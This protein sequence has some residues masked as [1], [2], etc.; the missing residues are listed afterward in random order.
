MARS[1][2]SLG[3][4]S[5]RAARIA[6]RRRAFMAGSGSPSLA[7]TVISRAS[8]ENNCE[9][10]L[11][12]RPLRCMMF[13]NCECPAMASPIDVWARSAP[14]GQR[15]R[16]DRRLPEWRRVI[17]WRLGKIQNAPAMADASIRHRTSDLTHA[18]GVLDRPDQGL[19]P[20]AQV[21]HQSRIGDEAAVVVDHGIGE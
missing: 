19:E 18:A 11:S 15:D 6:A 13:L 2:L 14:R 10:T 7:D 17:G 21:V 20:L 16:S 9:R 1:M 5:A 8:L 3:M 4:F 12:W